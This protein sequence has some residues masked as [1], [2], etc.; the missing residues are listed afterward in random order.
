MTTKK[1]ILVL[2]GDGIGK[3]V[4][5]AALP[6]LDAL[7]LPLELEHGEIGWESWRKIGNP[8]P[9]ET[10]EKIERADAVLLGAITSKPKRQAEEE[11]PE[12]LRGRAHRYVS[13]VIQLRQRLGLFANVRPS[14]FVS[15]DD[16]PYSLCVIRENTEG[17]YAGYDY[18]GIPA[19]LRGLLNHPNIEKYGPEATSVTLRLQTKLG[20][21]RLF[22]FAFRYALDHGFEQVTFADKPNVL[23]E[24]GHFAEEIL[25]EVA[26]RFPGV[27]HDIQNVDAVALWLTTRPE[28]FGVIV[29]ENMFGDILS[30][31][32]GGIMGGLGM[33]PSGNYGVK[34][35]YFEPVHGSAPVMAG[36][37]KANPSAMFLTIALLLDHIGFRVEAERVKAAVMTV[38]RKGRDRTYDY[39]GSASTSAFAGEVIEAVN[40][41]RY[42]RTAAVVA[43]GDEL[44]RG[45][46]ANTNATEIARSLH[47][48][49]FEVNEHSVCGDQKSSIARAVTRYLGDRDLVVVTGG[50]GPT[51]D[52]ATR[53]AVA[54]ALGL[55]LEFRQAAWDH[56]T[57]RMAKLG[58]SIRETD[59]VQASIPAGAALVANDQGMACGFM[60]TRHG[61]Q[62]VV[63][64]GPPHEM[65][66]VLRAALAGVE[67]GGE[68]GRKFVWTLLGVTETDANDTIAKLSSKL[69]PLVGYLWKYP[70]VLVSLRVDEV[71]PEIDEFVNRVTEAFSAN[72]VNTTGK[73]A[74]EMLGGNPSVRFR[75][76]DAALQALLAELPGAPNGDVFLVNTTPAFSDVLAGKES[77][78][79]LRITCQ[80]PLGERYEISAA[81]RGPEVAEYVR[82]FSCWSYARSSQKRPH[83]HG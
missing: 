47:E 35:A 19:E 4:C 30:D 67:A 5:D 63:L 24:S 52:D 27:R 64:P 77:S 41:R 7:R 80:S 44:L 3:E 8:V 26:A 21:E 39:G 69:A 29:A 70:Y 51:S 36:K 18:A 75:S 9:E 25:H 43:V 72:I 20:L 76:D 45:D 40:G 68:A 28:R 83:A 34:Q 42:R 2:P 78:G 71:T 50:L 56:I 55:P 59:R 14:Y 53:F 62:F 11:L 13:P 66:A 65:R 10:W 48:F 17:L 37:N 15:G 81:L 79:T 49:G 54:D 33:A 1:K 61:T 46:Y 74:V 22:E 6:V 31:L 23:R 58:L 82:Q 73:S 57:A 38:V 16:K 12:H 32:A 60:V